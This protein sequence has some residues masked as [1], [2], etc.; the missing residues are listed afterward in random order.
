MSDIYKKNDYDVEKRIRTDER[1]KTINIFSNKTDFHYDPKLG[2]P[3]ELE[4]FD[5]T[6]LPHDFFVI[7]E[8]RRRIGKTFFAKWLLSFYQDVFDMVIVLTKTDMNNFWQPI[9]G[10]SFVHHGWKPELVEQIIERNRIRVD[11]LGKEDPGNKVLIVL[12]DIISENIH[13]DKVISQLAVEGRHYD[14]AV[15]ILTQKPK[16]IGTALRD[17]CDVA[18]IFN[19]RTIRSRE[20]CYEDFM[21]S[22][23]KKEA[24]GLL[25]ANTEQ[26]SCIVVQN[27]V[28]GNERKEL[29]KKCTAEEVP[30]YILG[31]EGQRAIYYQDLKRGKIKSNTKTNGGIKHDNKQHSGTGNGGPIR[32]H[33]RQGLQFDKSYEK[34]DKTRRRA[35]KLDYGKWAYGPF[36]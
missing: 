32:N 36:S 22:M 10:P 35:N 17:N 7:L 6:T 1:E 23:D 11:K 29:Y 25:D 9:V 19:Q 5:P 26:H 20:A 3:E 28:L 24:L 14:I 12:D 27:Y 30:D 31:G 2:F 16:A 15:L 33:H 13:D 34:F 4:E 18:V 8:G 21:G